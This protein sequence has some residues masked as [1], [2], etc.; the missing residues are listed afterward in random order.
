M[1][2]FDLIIRGGTIVDGTGAPRFIGDVAIKDGVIAAVGTIAGDATREIDANGKIV[3]PGFVDIHTH[4]DGQA[5][6]DQEMAPSS[7]HGVTTVVMGNCGVGFAPAKPDRHEWLISLME[8]VE[9]IPG[10]AL[11]EGITW[12][13]ETFP[14]YLDALEKLPRTVDIGTH[15]PHGAVRAYVLGSVSNPARCRPQ[16]TSPK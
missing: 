8:G 3:A 12:D 14:E 2:A 15:V 16:K 11:S 10:T 9:D 13:W 7:W 4:Y 6:W 5:T 1:P